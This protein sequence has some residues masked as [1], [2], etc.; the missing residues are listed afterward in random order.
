VLDTLT[1]LLEASA[2][3]PW[4]LAAVLLIAVG[5]ALVPPIPSEGVVVAL[6]AVAVAGHGPDLVLLALV[7][8][9]GAFLGD[10]LTFLVGRRHGP[11]RIARTTRPGP[12]R[13]LDRAASTLERRGAL[14]VLTA[15]Y[16][17]LGRVAVNL[18][19]G[20]TGFPPRRFLGLA[21]LAAATWAGWS[22][23]LGAVAGHWLEG[24]PLLGSL[25]GVTLALGLGL[26]V[27]RAA[28][29]L[30]GWGRVATAAA[31]DDVPP[32]AVPFAL[33]TRECQ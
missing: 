8:A 15:R 12:R 1:A 3:A 25:A 2:A 14:V 5:D 19:A 9:V 13:L 17:P 18:T 4:V 23:A 28:R 33:S 26:L 24:S 7:A 32:G 10:T 6:A 29:R 16:V 27:D 22:V 11:A 30:T 20:A 21:A 31:S